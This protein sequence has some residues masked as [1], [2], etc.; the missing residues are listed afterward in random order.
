MRITNA[1]ML[2]TSKFYKK[3]IKQGLRAIQARKDTVTRRRL[4][5]EELQRAK[6]RKEKE[7]KAE[8][9]SF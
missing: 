5:A 4:L 6:E 7:A 9:D 2:Y 8:D 3:D 1:L